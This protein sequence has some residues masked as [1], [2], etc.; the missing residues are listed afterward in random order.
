MSEFE[1]IQGEQTAEN[2]SKAT[3]PREE[4]VLP[5]TEADSF[6]FSTNDKS[7]TEYME[8]HKHPNHVTYKKKWRISAEI[9]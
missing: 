6:E 7:Q 2:I 5:R 4:N 8:V 3:I 1:N 9:F